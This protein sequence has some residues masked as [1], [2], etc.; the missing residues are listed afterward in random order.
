MLSA[1]SFQEFRGINR[2]L[3][4]KV[5]VEDG[6]VVWI[7]TGTSVI[8]VE[9]T[10]GILGERARRFMHPSVDV[11]IPNCTKSK[12]RLPT[13]YRSNCAHD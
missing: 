5:E 7:R 9:V 1:F 13:G 2:K 4:V 10:R 3:V 11:D 6:V 8:K 12:L